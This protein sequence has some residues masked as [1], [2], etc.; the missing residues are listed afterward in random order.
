MMNRIIAARELLANRKL[1][2]LYGGESA[3]REVS[4]NS[5]QAVSDALT[6]V[7]LQHQLIDA[8]GNWL[9]T[10]LASDIDQVFIA[11]HGGQ[12]ED[13][14]LQG[15]LDLAGIDYTGS[16]VLA[17][18]LAMDKWRSKLL[19][20]AIGIKTPPFVILN[21]NTQWSEALASVGGK[22]MVKPAREGSSVGMCVVENAAELEKAYATAQHY[23]D[24]VI[25]ERWISGA[26]Y[27]VTVLADEALPA[28]RLE[29]DSTFYDY[30]AKYISDDTRYH[31]PAGLSEPREQQLRSLA[32]EVYE[33]VGCRGWARVD[34]LAEG[35]EFYVLEINTA[36]G[37]T[38]HSLVPMA[39][40]EAGLKFSD[41][42]LLILTAN[43]GGVV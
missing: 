14:T 16:G 24:V 2:V 21:K 4:L 15:A 42:V 3:E 6:S 38:S 9:S 32:L 33:S 29:T 19:W 18:A 25:A 30:E 13:G 27:T 36:P 1:A 23:D 11:L 17:S 31:C 41:L 40:K 43:A 7:G 28:I 5:G 10:L 12:G 34:F 26:E 8:S 39:A 20:S 37:L 22:A 35:D